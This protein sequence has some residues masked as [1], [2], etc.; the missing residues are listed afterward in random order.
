MVKI[1]INIEK[2]HIYLLAFI[3]SFLG[4]FIVIGATPFD[5]NLGWHPLQQIATDE[6]GTAS[7]DANSN[8]VIDKAENLEVVNGI[9]TVGNGTGNS[10]LAVKGGSGFYSSI[11]F[12][13]GSTNEWGIGKDT[14]G[15]FYI[16]KSGVGNA[17]TIDG[18]RNVQLVGSIKIGPDSSECTSAN[19]GA[20]RY[21]SVGKVMEYCNSTD[22]KLFKNPE[23]G[24]VYIGQESKNTH[25]GSCYQNVHHTITCDAVWDGMY[26]Y[27]D[28]DTPYNP[29]RTDCP[30]CNFGDYGEVIGTAGP[31][32]KVYVST[33]TSWAYPSHDYTGIRGPNYGVTA[34]YHGPSR[35]EPDV[36]S[37]G[38][39]SVL[40]ENGKVLETWR[41]DTCGSDNSQFTMVDIYECQ[42]IN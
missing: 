26:L 21:N 12:Y 25:F 15:N 8:A 14:N 10:I 29:D 18:N 6:T 13:S 2:K 5:P 17:L 36:I 11:D 31:G 37:G 40:S 9:S 42:K 39:D 1:Q 4:V 20:Q 27:G 19:E 41:G 34:P 16:D 32:I 33:S 23:Y 35:G 3:F 28:R 38:Y 30:T 7:V 24:W 22:W